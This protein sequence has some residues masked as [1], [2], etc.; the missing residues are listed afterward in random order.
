MAQ[1]LGGILGNMFGMG[2]PTAQQPGSLGQDPMQ[3]MGL[4]G[5]MQYLQQN[6][7]EALMALGSGMMQGNM[8]GGFAAA[9]DQMTAHR[10]KAAEQ[11]KV[12][13]GENLTKRWLMSN[14]GLSAVSVH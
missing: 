4:L 10:E 11:Q 5:R 9:G 2:Q 8:A 13:Q 3:G 6:N 7:P 14:K 12:A 1:G